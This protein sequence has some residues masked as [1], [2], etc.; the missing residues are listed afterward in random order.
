MFPVIDDW[1]AFKQRVELICGLILDGISGKTHLVSTDEK[2]GIQALERTIV[3]SKG[4]QRTE[5]EYRRNGT[6]CLLAAFDVGKG[7]MMDHLLRDTR[8]EPDYLELVQSLVSKY[9]AQDEVV[10]LADQLNTHMSASL[11][12]WIA[13]EIGFEGELGKKRGKGILKS[14][15]SRKEFLE[16][17]SHRIRFV[18]TPKHCSWLNPVENWFAKLQ[19]QVINRGS[20]ASVEQL[21]HKIEAYIDYY[22]T[23]L[24]K[25]LKWKFNGFTKDHKLHQ[26]NSQ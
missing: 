7:V 1:E 21:C 20:F 2:T 3:Y 8:K 11:V 15:K 13:G 6:I 9:P 5:Y 25:P 26:I 10:I 16:D 19:K 24:V 12:E 18:Y 4:N 17:T 14:M 22:N 23:A